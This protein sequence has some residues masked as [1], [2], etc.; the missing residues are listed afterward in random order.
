MNDTAGQ[1]K[2][3]KQN[4]IIILSCL[5]TSDHN[6]RTQIHAVECWHA[7]PAYTPLQPTVVYDSADTASSSG[8]H[9]H[10]KLLR[11]PSIS[12]RRDGA[13][14]VVVVGASVVVVVLGACVV[15]VFVIFWAE[16]S[17]FVFVWSVDGLLP[18]FESVVS[19]SPFFCAVSATGL[20]GLP[21]IPDPPGPSFVIGTELAGPGLPAGAVTTLG[22]SGRACPAPRV[23]CVSDPSLFPGDAAAATAELDVVEVFVAPEAPVSCD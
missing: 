7:Q 13:R 16:S 21:E 15:V 5:F 20:S 22:V 9:T 6:G 1:Q 8:A 11:L 23:P 12:R 18:V 14:V 2:Q 4:T 19:L 17:G 3:M 10:A